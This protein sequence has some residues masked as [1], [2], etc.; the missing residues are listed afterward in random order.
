[1][2][3]NSKGKIL[4][5]YVKVYSNGFNLIAFFLTKILNFYKIEN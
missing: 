3:Y 5:I 4:Y 1:M 2:F